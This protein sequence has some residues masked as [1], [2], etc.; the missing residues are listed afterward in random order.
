ML[1]AFRHPMSTLACG[2]MLVGALASIPASGAFAQPTS[3]AQDIA[4][5]VGRYAAEKTEET[6]K[7]QSKRAI[8]AAYKRLYG[9]GADK[10]LLRTLGNVALSA[11]E[12]DT[13]ASNMAKAT[14]LGD[15]EGVK[16]V[17]QQVAVALGKQML[18]GL[19]DPALRGKMGKLLG[20]VDKI[21]E[22]A[23]VAGQAAGG[24]NSAALE[25]VGRAIIAATPA[26]NSTRS[27]TTSN[28]PR[29]ANPPRRSESVKRGTA[30]ER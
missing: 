10:R 16:G 22:I 4:A 6:I 18:A 26:I 8:I 30:N 9:S 5:A 19:S 27:G 14:V 15:P 3:V 25:F 2:L 29:H 28:P 24:D 12:I 7:E 11:E 23:D 13:L 21:N 1:H 17:G 20:S